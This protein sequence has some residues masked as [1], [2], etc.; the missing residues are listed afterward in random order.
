MAHTFTDEGLS[1][2][3]GQWPRSALAISGVHYIGLYASAAPTT[4]SSQV[5]SRTAVGGATHAAWTE[6]TGGSY[7]RQVIS[8]GDWGAQNSN[9]N[10]I[11]VSGKQVAFTATAT[12]SPAVGFFL[13]TNSADH[14][15]DDVFYFS[16]FDSLTIRSLVSGDVLQLTPTIQF[17]VSALA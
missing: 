11:R 2:L 10:G 1:G 4:A 5:P 12:W 3:L 16:N 7:A 14:A 6:V 9:G 15:N 17:N 13:S 8:A